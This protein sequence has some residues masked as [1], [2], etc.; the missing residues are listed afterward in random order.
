MEPTTKLQI[1][2]A[3]ADLNLNGYNWCY[4]EKGLHTFSRKAKTGYE[5]IKA[6][7][8]DLTNGDI[9]YMIEHNLSR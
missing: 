7:A 3:I 4:F 5:V 2:A 8:D 9:E 1:A 6:K